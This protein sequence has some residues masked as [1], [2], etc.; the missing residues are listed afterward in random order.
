MS[1]QR[2]KNASKTY[3][4]LNDR[5]HVLERPGMFIGGHK[6]IKKEQL[7]FDSK[8]NKIVNKEIDIVPGLFKIY[9]EIIVNA[10]DHYL[11]SKIEKKEPVTKI[12]IKVNKEEGWISVLNDGHGIPIVKHDTFQVYIPEMI[13]GELRSSSNFSQKGKEEKRLTGGLN[14]YGAK[15]T[16]IFSKE[17]I[18]ETVD[19]DE[20]LYFKQTYKNNMSEK[21]TP[22]IKEYT[23]K[24]SYTKITFYPDFEYFG[25]SGFNDDYLDLF[26]RRA[27]DIATDVTATVSFN[28]DILNY[29]KFVDYVKLYLDDSAEIVFDSNE[30]WKVAAVFDRSDIISHKNISF[31][32]GIS[33][34]EGGKHVD[35]I[36]EQIV[37]ALKEKLA[38]K[39]KN[40]QIKPAVIKDNLTMFISA[41]I[42]NPDFSGQAKEKLQTPPKNFGTEFTISP[43]FIVK[44]TKT[45]IMD[46]IIATLQAKEDKSLNSLA[47]KSKYH[48]EKLSPA[49]YAGTKRSKECTLILTEGDSAKTF[50]LAATNLIGRDLYGIFPLKG[51]FV[52]C[53]GKQENMI[54]ANEQ[55][56]ALI[57]IMG[58][59]YNKKY[60]DS[61]ELNYG[62]ILILTDQDVDGYH[63]K[64]L[65]MNFFY[66]FW[67]EL[68]TQTDFIQSLATPLI[69]SYNIKDKTKMVFY[70]EVQY[71]EWKKT[72]DA[73]KWKSKYYKGLATNNPP[74]AIECFTDYH[75]KIINYY[76]DDSNFKTTEQDLDYEPIE[77][78]PKYKNKTYES[79]DLVFGD[80]RQD[81][82]KKWIN[83]FDEENSYV[84]NSI[85]QVPYYDFLNKEML[86]YSYDNVT[87]S[88]PRI[89]DI[90][91][92]G[93]R[94]IIAC[95]LNKNLY[96]EEGI[97]V[98][99]LAGAVSETMDYHHGEDSLNG[100]IV[101]M[102]R[103]FV[104][105]NNLNI[106]IPNGLFGSRVEGG[107]DA[108]SPRYIQTSLN[109]LAKIIFNN[110]DLA[111]IEYNYDDN[112]TK[113]EPKFYV[114]VV[115]YQLFN[116]VAGI[117]TGYST[118][119]PAYNPIDICNNIYKFL[120]NE[121]MD[122]IHP[123]Y[124][125]FKGSIVEESP[126]KYNCNGVYTIDKDTIIIT[127][128]PI[129]VWTTSF[130]K[131][132]DEFLEIKQQLKVS[133]KNEEKN[134]LKTMGRSTSK[135]KGKSTS[136]T[137]SI[138]LSTAKGA[139][140]E[141]KINTL[142]Q[143]IANSLVDYK[144]DYTDIRIYFELY[145]EEGSLEKLLKNPE[146][147]KKL[148]LQTKI[149][150]TN[151]T[152][153]DKNNSIKKYESINDILTE[154]C[155]VRLE[156]YNIR[157]NYLLGKLKKEI[158]I[159][160]WKLKFILAVINKEI[161]LFSKNNLQSKKQWI[162]L[163][164]QNEYPKFENSSGAFNYSYILDIPIY[165]FT[166]EEVNKLRNNVE[167]KTAIYKDL[168]SKSN[169]DLWK[170]ELDIFV[171]E[172]NKWC[173][174]I[175][176]EY[177][178]V[179]N[180]KKDEL[181][182]LKKKKKLTRRN[183]K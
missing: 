119:I 173:I 82:R 26:K 55:V 128:L 145:F 147:L 96:S 27:C 152:L 8:S 150:V 54:K 34:E 136:K 99:Q 109:L 1:S 129:G 116:S 171:E 172:Y 17:F 94:K 149:A 106:L 75:K 174:E 28:D 43:T 31:V 24:T 112:L 41:H 63:I 139:P 134:A 101:N 162:E 52:N 72:V 178:K 140:K 93:Q 130:K 156:Y 3:N 30:H 118:S 182:K 159:L 56:C 29:S 66:Y 108:G 69:R 97:R 33:T 48:N 38:K 47:K 164:E 87:R 11:E 102:A 168:K 67:P 42:Y 143:E 35:Y 177:N 53:I 68:L 181:N 158:D 37:T 103:N 95:C 19:L 100:T 183:T 111:V 132:L 88:M 76:T 32:N 121:E 142:M 114:P 167:K 169:R 39:L 6:S 60:K 5:E 137:T 91:K 123:W 180:M 78:I 135:S 122:D 4:K 21:G 79:F 126:K 92:P 80:E 113:I 25:L 45:G 138:K 50:A 175:E 163:L 36:T 73:N 9:D 127:E 89:Q 151:I 2:S 74:D 157:K 148:N 44:L 165:N 131:M 18:V 77:Y 59:D 104:G 7:V 120:E 133:S 90:L 105:T 49:A 155:D 62:H 15:L 115:P 10:R 166:E 84:D 125:F 170:E 22:I 20:K 83:N 141:K 86:A 65:V 107:D 154:F 40:I 98:A 71:K 51:K 57:N 81:D 46:R 146:F 12:Q 58:L 160:N 161:I 124:R 64:G 179:Y 117:G 70:N 14:G 85:K 61:S 16:N 23:K 153:V 176:K 144:E 13:F 110:D